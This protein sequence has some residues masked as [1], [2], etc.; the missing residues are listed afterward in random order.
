MSKSTSAPL[1]FNARGEVTIPFSV[2]GI[3]FGERELSA[4]VATLNTVRKAA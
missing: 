2:V 1:R 4:I 3:A